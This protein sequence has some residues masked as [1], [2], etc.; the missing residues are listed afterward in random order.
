MFDVILELESSAKRYQLVRRK[1]I[2]KKDVKD[3]ESPSQLS[4]WKYQK[5]ISFRIKK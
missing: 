1:K 4:I 5:S 3:K 2:L